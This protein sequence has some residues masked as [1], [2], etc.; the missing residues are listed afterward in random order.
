MIRKYPSS[1]Y[2][3]ST[4][5]DQPDVTTTKR[6]LNAKRKREIRTTD[7]TRSRRYSFGNGFRSF[8]VLPDDLV[9][10]ATQERD[11]RIVTVRFGSSAAYRYVISLATAIAREPAVRLEIIKPLHPECQLLLLAVVQPLDTSPAKFGRVEMWR[12]GFRFGVVCC[13][14]F[15][16]AVP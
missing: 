14:P 12:G 10:E 8:K 16:L 3:S 11:P 2:H 7:I 13:R 4:I 5:F 6:S 1:Q 9:F 15:R